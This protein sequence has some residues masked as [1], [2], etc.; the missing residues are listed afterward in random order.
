MQRF[1]RLNGALI[2]AGVLA[3]GLSAGAAR[4]DAA[5][6]AT[7]VSELVLVGAKEA[8]A[9]GA[10]AA[11]PIREI[12]QTV[13]VIGQTRIVEQNLFTLEDLMTQVPGITI[14]G[15]SPESPAYMSRGFSI[16]AYLIDGVA[17]IGY[18][19]STPDM[20]IYERVEV[21]RGAA[22]LYSGTASP[23]GSIN[24][25]R[26][27]PTE[28]FHASGSF[29]AGSWNNYRIEGD[30]SG[31]LL[32]S[33][34]LRGRLV[35]AFQDQD[36]F[37]DVAH[38]RRAIVYGAL[39][40]ELTPQTTLTI[41][42]H[43]QDFKPA[44]QT[45]LPGYTTGGL[46]KVSRS[47]FLGADWNR[48]RTQDTVAFAE[49]AHEFTGGWRVRA[50]AQTA[51]QERMDKYAYVG[52]GAVKPHD[53]FTNQIAYS[54]ENFTRQNSFDVNL[55]GAVS[56]F[57]ASHDLL[58]GADYQT[59]DNKYAE[60]R[61][62]A[63]ARI[64]VFNPVTAVPEPFYGNNGGGLQE[65]EQYGVYGNARLRPFDNTIVTLGGRFSWYENS[66]RSGGTRATPTNPPQPWTYGPSS[67]Y[68]V[69]HEFTPYVGVV[70]DLN[71]TWS[72][73]ASYADTLTPQSTRTV[74][75]DF[76]DPIIGE[77]VEAGVKA[78]FFDK[79]LLLS[80][81]VY[82]INQVNRSQP[83]PDNEGFYI[84]TGEVLSKG[85]EL[86]AMGQITNNW[87]VNAGYSYNKNEYETDV[88]N[89]GKPFTLVS[90]KHM[91]K[92]YTNY[93]FTDGP[94]AGFDVGA[95][96]NAFGETVG[97][98]LPIA[99]RQPAYAVVNANVG[100]R[101]NEDVTLRLSV[102]NLFDEVYYARISGVGRGNYYGEPRSVAVS[103]RAAY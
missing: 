82:R 73:Y 64:D 3:A 69:E 60:W 5:D 58:I 57:G 71:E 41:G 67:T 91:F 89:G 11:T 45:G 33:G 80:G 40:Y 98:T 56:L 44:N 50:T 48:F 34:R 18:P 42:G 6:D 63:F 97:G 103:I 15:V 87:R 46:L 2:S 14:T 21:L 55:S 88:N 65:I 43:Y 70:H 27:R 10:K 23:A 32:D 92:A 100:Y 36:L 59:K 25:V 54:G 61:H 38:K 62:S 99:V 35:G 76:L 51:Q 77:Q 9:A 74:E 19:G 26:K 8:G 78:E 24:L 4:A 1:G 16:D 7:T 96:L 52:S 31:P 90:P 93:R 72:I 17:G 53:G 30:I 102:N 95:G 101:V 68:K 66:S 79:R 29:M 22:S 85:V 83:D 12:P 81:A 13:T 86:E 75:G 47:T 28:D 49:L 84:A 20:S 37:Y 39:A 94:L